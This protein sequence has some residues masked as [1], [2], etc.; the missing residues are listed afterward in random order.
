MSGYS[1]FVEAGLTL[2]IESILVRPQRGFKNIVLPDGSIMS[3]FAAQAVVEEKHHDEMEITNH[4]ME[5]GANIT[6]HMFKHP[7]E[8]TLRL[9]WSNSPSSNGSLVNAGLA[10]AA[11]LS[12][13]ISA[14]A[15]V[16][17]I[18]QGAYGL[19]SGLNGS[20]VDQ[21]KMIYGMLLQLQSRRALF[22]LYTGKRV[23]TNM[24]CKTL[25]SE[26][27]FKTEHS[28][29]ITMT[30]K[31]IILVNSYTTELPKSTQAKPAKT[32]SPVSKGSISA[33][34]AAALKGVNP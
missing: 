22:T 8:V 11:S 20:E 7:A 24:V 16:G 34:P 18:V 29:P 26:N 28:L 27:D 23:Y 6:D 31:Q 2:G 3:D 32:A 33:I 25:M 19:L 4:P 14:I 12:P 13:A 9:G 10:A 15:N 30:C 21:I 5:Q 1:G 17:S